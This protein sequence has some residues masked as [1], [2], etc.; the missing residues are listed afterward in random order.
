MQITSP[1]ERQNSL[2]LEYLNPREKAPTG[3]S[4]VPTGF[5]APLVSPLGN[6]GQS[7]ISTGRGFATWRAFV[8]QHTPAGRGRVLFPVPHWRKVGRSS[9]LIPTTHRPVYTVRVGTDQRG[10]KRRRR[11]LVLSPCSD[12]FAVEISGKQG[13]HR[14]DGK[15]PALPLRVSAQHALSMEKVPLYLTLP[16]QHAPSMTT[17]PFCLSECLPS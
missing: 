4:S 5:P 16:A 9:T 3:G 10:K 6:M 11:C 2:P 12:C 8:R 7:A 1:A 14:L 15:S 13:Q 17:A